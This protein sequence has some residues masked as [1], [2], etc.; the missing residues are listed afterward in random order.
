MIAVRIEIKRIDS[1]KSIKTTGLLD[2]GFASTDPMLPE[3]YIP[4]R[5]AEKMGFKLN[6]GLHIKST[7][8]I[9]EIDL[10][11]LGDVA[12]RL[13]VNDRDTPW[14]K[15]VAVTTPIGVPYVVLSS[16][17][18]E[19]LNIAIISLRGLGVW[20]F[21]DEIGKFRSGEPIECW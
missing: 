13:C 12:V 5:L 6:R 1:D 4:A 17:L 11:I 18:I 10:N 21:K 7:I 9:Y 20:S 2:T 3:I 16:E 15:A 14:V 19:D 8:S